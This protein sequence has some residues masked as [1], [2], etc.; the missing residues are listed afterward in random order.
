MGRFSLKQ[1]RSFRLKMGASNAQFPNAGLALPGINSSPCL[2]ALAM[3]LCTIRLGPPFRKND[4]IS[5][6]K[7]EGV[8][9]KGEGD[10][11]PG[12]GEPMGEFFFFLLLLGIFASNNVLEQFN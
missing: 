12:M 3:A 6:D 9:P 1:L 2:A 10:G 11:Q 8:L 5:S 4:G 7:K